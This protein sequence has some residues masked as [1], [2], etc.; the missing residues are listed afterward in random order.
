M[1][2]T[3]NALLAGFRTE[4]VTEFNKAWNVRATATDGWRAISTEKSST[5]DNNDYGFYRDPSKPRQWIGNRVVTNLEAR[6]YV[7]WNLDWEYTFG[8]AAND[9]RDD[10]FGMLVDK[11]TNLA[12]VMH[13]FIEE[14]VFKGMRDGD[15]PASLCWDGTPYFIA[16]H[17]GKTG[18]PNVWSNLTA[19]GGGNPWVV[20]DSKAALHGMIFQQREAPSF[21]LLLGLESEY[22]KQ[23]NNIMW[24]SKG[25]WVVGYGDPSTCFQSHQPVTEA[26]LTLA[27]D[28]LGALLDDELRPLNR[29]A[30][31]V[32]CDK[33]LESQF[34]RLIN[35]ERIFDPV[36]AQNVENLWYNQLR[37][38]ANGFM[39]P[40]A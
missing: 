33:T 28:A 1:P 22:C 23:T 15:L 19:A 16:T 11:T 27:I 20:M 5:G 17:P 14:Q 37:I 10:K 6:H 31:T 40:A 21:D 32:I 25:R 35:K 4:L 24:G 29:S 12:N 36:G 39:D 7:L 34:K 9:L 2:I 38:I 3:Q 26:N 8:S 13:S 18:T 30:D